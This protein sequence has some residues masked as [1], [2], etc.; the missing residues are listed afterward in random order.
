MSWLTSSFVRTIV[1]PIAL[2]LATALGLGCYFETNDDAHLTFLF[3]GVTAAAPV[4]S[5]PLY[6]HGLGHGLAAAYTAAP[7]VPWYG[8]LLGGLLLVAT[9]LLF[10]VLNQLLRSHLRPAAIAVVLAVFFL[11]A[12]LENWLWF[13][14]VRVA[15][16]LAFS[17]LLLMAQRPRWFLLG[18]VVVV[19]GCL[20]RPG[21]AG[22]GLAAAIPAA[23]LLAGAGVGRLRPMAAGLGVWLL[24]QGVVFVIATPEAARFRALDSRLALIVDDELLRPAPSADRQTVAAVDSWLFGDETLVNTA[25]LSQ[26]YQLQGGY[27][28]ARTLPA[29]LQ[30]RFG[31][32]IRDYFPLWL[33]LGAAAMAATHLPPAARRHFWLVQA[34]FGLLLIS[35][36]GLLKLPPRLALP[37]L[38]GWL[39]ASLILLRPLLANGRW[40][41]SVRW[42][43]V[44]IG[45]GV[46]LAYAAKTWHRAQLLSAEC[47][48]NTRAVGQVADWRKAHALR[49]ADCPPRPISCL[50]LVL[51]GADN[52]FKS[53]SPF[54]TYSLGVGPVVTPTGWPSHLPA[55]RQLL[56]RLTHQAGQRAG[57]RWLAQRPPGEEPQWLLAAEVAPLLL[58][59]FERWQVVAELPF[60]GTPPLYWYR[61]KP[62][63]AH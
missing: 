25:A 1:L 16:L 45:G 32:L 17:G 23:Y 37:L 54:R 61:Q 60:L 2:V 63:L 31:L 6:F 11:L 44:T 62:L 7:A 22:L 33:L 30:L 50:P 24:V 53:L 13:S 18:L 21:A 26:C 39:L 27:F 9:I 52:L 42:A 5:L 46:L 4:P 3:Q 19:L 15:A 56:H 55:Q 49:P 8:L 59:C 34:Y 43:L 12:W 40:L 14:H 47:Q 38:D 10:T 41:V 28:L 36:A 51:G 58:P 29:K 35:L 57:L 20:I 48:R